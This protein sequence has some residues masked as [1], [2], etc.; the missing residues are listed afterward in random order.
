MVR[1]GLLVHALVNEIPLTLRSSH[2]A[3]RIRERAEV[4][5]ARCCRNDTMCLFA[6][7]A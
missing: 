1:P 5:A 7:R 3:L 2:I 6:A 4:I